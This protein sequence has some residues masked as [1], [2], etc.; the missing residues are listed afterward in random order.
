MVQIDEYSLTYEN[1][2]SG[3]IVS[4]CS[5]SEADAGGKLLNVVGW[6]EVRGDEQREPEGL[7]DEVGGET[8]VAEPSRGLSAV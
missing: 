3:I 5:R 1:V 8:T 7:G 4:G 6:V 2:G